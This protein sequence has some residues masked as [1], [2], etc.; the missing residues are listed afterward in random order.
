MKV[1]GKP[2]KRPR[3]RTIEHT[4]AAEPWL[5]PMRLAVHGI[6]RTGYRSPYLDSSQAGLSSLGETFPG[7]RSCSGPSRNGPAP[8]RERGNTHHTR[9]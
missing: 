9:A 8:V 3:P 5:R 6:E 2:A 1:M 4:E 7:V